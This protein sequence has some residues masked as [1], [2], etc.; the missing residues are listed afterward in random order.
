MR[1][2]FMLLLAVLL[3]AACPLYAY[4]EDVTDPAAET[5]AVAEEVTEE[6]TEATTEATTVV[7]DR[8]LNL[9]NTGDATF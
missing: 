1:K 2:V 6:T 7:S 8:K 5:E 3:V 9:F 4:A